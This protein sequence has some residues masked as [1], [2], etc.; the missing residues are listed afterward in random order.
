[1]EI[2]C[3]KKNELN[4]QKKETKIMI[5]FSSYSILKFLLLRSISYQVISYFNE[6]IKTHLENKSLKNKTN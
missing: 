4:R 3:F 1:M 5:H 2:T 6:I